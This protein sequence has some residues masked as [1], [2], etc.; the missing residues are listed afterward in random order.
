LLLL[1]RLLLCLLHAPVSKLGDGLV[2]EGLDVF[3]AG[4]V[5]E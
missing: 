5:F 3:A 1:L 4:G 2:E